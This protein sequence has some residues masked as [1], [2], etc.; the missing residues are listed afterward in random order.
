[1]ETCVA[2]IEDTRSK[3]DNEDEVSEVYAVEVPMEEVPIP[4][5]KR[6]E[7]LSQPASEQ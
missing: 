6:V 7:S 2:A 3:N 5:V 4:I 1:M